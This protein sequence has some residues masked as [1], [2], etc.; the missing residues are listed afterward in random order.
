MHRYTFMRARWHEQWCIKG[1]HIYIQIQHALLEP[2]SG[3]ELEHVLG[4]CQSPQGENSAHITQVWRQLEAS[5]FYSSHY[6]WISRGS[7]QRE[8]CPTLLHI[9]ASENRTPDLVI[10][11]TMP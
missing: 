5:L 6:C 1:K 3:T 4:Q 8:V 10:F 7:I 11:S 2:L 9:I